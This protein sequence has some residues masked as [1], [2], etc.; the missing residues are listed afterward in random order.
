MS[1]RSS[2]VWNFF[3]VTDKVQYIAECDMCKKSFSFKSSVSNLKKHMEKKHPFIKLLPE[4][5]S[6]RTN[7]EIAVAPSSSCSSQEDVNRIGN[8]RAVEK[9]Q[10]IMNI[11]LINNFFV[12]P[13]SITGFAS[14]KIVRKM[15]F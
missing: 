13:S 11:T 7:D 5:K 15:P 14:L 1:K 8:V 4:A 2:P 3:T 9:V 6:S 12:L 10:Y